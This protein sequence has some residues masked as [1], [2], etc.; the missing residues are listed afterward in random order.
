[1]YTKTKTATCR[2]GAYL[3]T[4]RVGIPCNKRAI[5]ANDFS[6]LAKG[7]TSVSHCP[8]SQKLFPTPWRQTRTE[9]ALRPAAPIKS[10]LHAAMVSYLLRPLVFGTRIEKAIGTYAQQLILSETLIALPLNL[11]SWQDWQNT[12]SINKKNAPGAQCK[13]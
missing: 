6:R 12:S 8:Q 2:A 7:F 10:T 11:T 4:V 5:S 1:M 9:A 3:V 13:S